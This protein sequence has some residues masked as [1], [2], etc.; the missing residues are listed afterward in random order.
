MTKKTDDSN[1]SPDAS[2][3][4]PGDSAQQDDTR[5]A[6]RDSGV[7]PAAAEPGVTDTGEA[8]YPPPADI[9]AG[10]REDG[11]STDG[12]PAPAGAPART[13]A[14]G[15]FSTFVSLLA[16]LLALGALSGVAWLAWQGRDGD[17]VARENEQ[18]IEA[19]E[20]RLQATLASVENIGSRIDELGG[21]SEQRSEL[22][23]AIERDLDD[24]ADRNLSLAERLATV[25]NALASLQGLSTAARDTWML[26]E[27]EHYIQ[28]ANAQL[29]LAGNPKVA[30]LALRFADE[31]IREAGNPALSEV[32]RSLRRELQAVEA[33]EPIDIE[34]MAHTLTSLANRVDDLALN[35]QL[36]QVLRA[37]EEAAPVDP[38]L[39]GFER[40][41]ASMKRAFGDVIS[42][43]RSDEAM[44]PLMSPDA[45]W[46]LRANLALKFEAARLALLKNEFGVFEQSLDDAA[47]W[48]R[49]YYDADSRPVANALAAISDLRNRSADVTWPDI[50]QSL[51]L[52]RQYRALRDGAAEP[53]Q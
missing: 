11:G 50:S 24:I 29:Q 16:V 44:T 40:A 30:A 39:S 33:I 31:R 13:P 32:R 28:I 53:A 21:T 3:S 6:D 12:E 1:E 52:L 8:D 25:E 18:A 10:E 15:P 7:E 43:R 38:D 37:D 48:L 27:A 26:A 46:F 5:P 49:D 2:T 45:A 20:Q 35:D 51:R 4:R 17:T 42:V 14:R 47:A 19:L 9:D 23:D 34:G 41:V 22:V 36:Q